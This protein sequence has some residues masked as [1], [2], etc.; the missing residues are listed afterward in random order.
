MA[1]I[2]FNTI[3]ESIYY[4]IKIPVIGI[5]KKIKNRTLVTSDNYKG[6]AIAASVFN[7][8]KSS[9]LVIGDKNKSIHSAREYSVKHFDSIIEGRKPFSWQIWRWI[10]F[11]RWYELTIS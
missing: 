2:V 9:A 11:A 7:K 1:L 4:E 3:D 10:N 6:G 8:N 5:E